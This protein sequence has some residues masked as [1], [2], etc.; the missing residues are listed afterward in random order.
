ESGND[1]AALNAARGC[2][3]RLF[4]G[5]PRFSLVR[6]RDAAARQLHSRGDVGGVELLE[7]RHVADDFAQIQHER[8]DFGFV[9][10]QSSQAGDVQHGLSRDDH[11]FA[12]G[13]IRARLGSQAG[14]GVWGGK[15]CRATTLE[16]HRRPCSENLANGASPP[17]TAA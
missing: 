9:E 6:A 10:L 17:T 4:V 5:E 3:Q 7:L 15:G 14:Y 16:Y 11:W 8:F 1:E 2:A 12:S 13:G